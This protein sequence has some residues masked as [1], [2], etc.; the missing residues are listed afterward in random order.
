MK[1][2]PDFGQSSIPTKSKC[3][4]EV[5]G[6]TKKPEFVLEVIAMAKGSKTVK[7]YACTQHVSLFQ[8]PFHGLPVKV[9]VHNLNPVTDA[10]LEREES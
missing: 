6:C 4:A 8:V 2:R 9:E 7:R 3:W 10:A 5:F 1:R